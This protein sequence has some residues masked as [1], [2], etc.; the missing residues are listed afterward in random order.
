V[1]EQ[2]FCSACGTSLS[3][4]RL[5][6]ATKGST[7]GR[8]LTTVVFCDLVGSSALA[9][10]L[11]PEEYGALLVAYRG[12]CAAAVKHGGGYISS[13][14]GDG[15]MAC[16]GYPRAVGRDA[17]AAVACGLA[18]TREITALATS[19]SL[20][21]VS[22][23]AVRVGIE[24]GIVVAGPLGTED[25]ME[26]DAL[27]GPAPYT[28]ARL[29]ELAPPNGVVIGGA[30]HELVA[31]DFVC[32]ELPPERL[33]RLSAPA[34]AYVVRGEVTR[35]VRHLVLARRRAPWSGAPLSLR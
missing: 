24:T 16:F 20:L 14:I 21:G 7:A 25:A 32:E 9:A 1:P 23:L 10:R 6:G 8:R 13:Y 4:T 35:S 34:Q 12:R 33:I 27:V 22:E 18:I 26:F 5:S 15:V 31:E 2:R 30:T 28:A 19:K 17:Q 11:D 3:P 29:Q